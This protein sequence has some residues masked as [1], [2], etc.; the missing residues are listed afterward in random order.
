MEADSPSIEGWIMEYVTG[1]VQKGAV[2]LESP[3]KGMI[4]NRQQTAPHNHA[5]CS[6]HPGEGNSKQ[7]EKKS[8]GSSHTI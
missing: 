2:L 3:L 1:D 5:A 8:Q 7:H 6:R 4:S